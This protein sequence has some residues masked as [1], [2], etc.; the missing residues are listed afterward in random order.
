[1]TFNYIADSFVSFALYADVVQRDARLFEA[2]EAL[3]EADIDGLLALSAQRIL[4][5]IQVSD[6]WRQYMFARDSSLQNDIRSVPAVNPTKI[7]G[8][9]QD[10][11][12]LNVFY[13]LAEYILP[14]VA[15]FSKERSGFDSAEVV[16]IHFYRDA[17]N[18]LFKEIYEA[19]DWYDFNGDTNISKSEKQPTLMNRVRIR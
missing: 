10:F 16:K 5:K 14:G 18:D 8:R 4:N 13:C 19:G 9:I 11:K 6:W 1:M 2:N 3:S 17:Y 15:D 12:D 7:D